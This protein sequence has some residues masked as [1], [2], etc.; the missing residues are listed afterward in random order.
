MSDFT[1][2][3]A[4]LAFLLTLVNANRIPGVDLSALFPADEAARYAFLEK[5]GFALASHGHMRIENRQFHDLN[6]LLPLAVATLAAPEQ[7]IH[8]TA[9]AAAGELQAAHYLAGVNVVEFYITPEGNYRVV[10]LDSVETAIRTIAHNLGV[11]HSG[12]MHVLSLTIAPELLADNADIRAA[13]AAALAESD[14]PPADGT[15]IMGA[16]S[17]LDRVA[18]IDLAHIVD[19]TIQRQDAILL[20][21]VEGTVGML[22]TRKL[23][24]TTLT[25][26][27]SAGFEKTVLEGVHTLQ[28]MRQAV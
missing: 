17:S 10:V 15:R 13:V 27:A 1:L 5:G 2:E 12:N 23:G 21:Q 3:P 24:A 20:F 28:A 11:V 7:I 26:P 16:I 9:Y 4:E 22:H 25:I 18:E 14:I 19:G 6:P 8:T